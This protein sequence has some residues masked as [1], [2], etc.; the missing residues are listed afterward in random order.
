MSPPEGIDLLGSPPAP[1]CISAT[2]R[3]V[4]VTGL[5]NPCIQID[6]FQKALMAAT[7]D[8]DAR[9]PDPQGRGDEHRA[10]RRRR[11]T[12][13][14]PIRC[15]TCRTAPHKPLQSDRPDYNKVV[16]ADRLSWPLCPTPPTILVFDSG[17][18]G[19]TVFREIVKLRPDAALRLRRRRRVISPMASIPRRNRRAGGTADRRA[20][21]P[22]TGRILW[23]SPATPPRPWS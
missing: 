17:L 6:H 9:Q 13:A 3:V 23:S 18:G 7:L 10:G 5:R 19:L 15:R 1:C 8:K 20:D 21:R 16:T 14:T 11:P 22:N 4:E 2:A 12:R